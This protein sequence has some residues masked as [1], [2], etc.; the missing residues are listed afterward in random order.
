MFDVILKLAAQKAPKPLEQLTEQLEPKPLEQSTLQDELK[1][2]EQSMLQDE[3]KPLEQ[4]MLQEEVQL[5]KKKPPGQESLW[6]LQV[7]CDEKKDEQ[8]SPLVKLPQW[9][10][11]PVD[12][13]VKSSN[14]K[15]EQVI[16]LPLWLEQDPKPEWNPESNPV[17][18][19]EQDGP[20]DP[21]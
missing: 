13:P 21:L 11:K 16:L 14:P 4:S 12:P 3:L 6:T 20:N 9:K 1:P 10:L 15:E 8:V 17:L 18:K 5:E 19:L 7:V 2:L